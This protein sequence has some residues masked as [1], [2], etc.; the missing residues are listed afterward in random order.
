MMKQR[1][2]FGETTIM[3]KNVQS[4]IQAQ[5]NTVSSM[6]DHSSGCINSFEIQMKTHIETI[7]NHHNKHY[8]KWGLGQSVVLNTH[9][10]IL[11]QNQ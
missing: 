9:S 4:Q 7:L 2:I 11:D 3:G 5:Q 6:H 8:N 10:C 1:C